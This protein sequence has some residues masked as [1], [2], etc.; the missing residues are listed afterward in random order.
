MS[1]R[2]YL[3][4]AI[5][6]A[7]TSAR[8]ANDR[9]NEY[10]ADARRGLA[11]WHDHFIGTHGG[12]VVLDVR[13]EEEEA[14]LDGSAAQVLRRVTL[15]RAA[16]GIAAAALWVVVSTAGEMSVTDLFQ[17]R[18]YAEELYTGIAIGGGRSAGKTM[19]GSPEKGTQ[20]ATPITIA[21]AASNW[22]ITEL[23]GSF[24]ER[25][26]VDSAMIT[27]APCRVHEH[28][29]GLRRLISVHSASH[30]PNHPV[31]AYNEVEAQSS[32]SHLAPLT[33]GCV[34]VY[35]A[36]GY[37]APRQS[38]ARPAFQSAP[39]APARKAPVKSA[40]ATARPVASPARALGQSLARAFGGAAEVPAAKDQD[41]TEF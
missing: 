40:S 33:P 3:V 25:R 22:R 2:C 20:A 41:W 19:A 10:V 12:A 31:G 4:Y 27:A 39:A 24:R 30:H 8:E 16:S 13:S 17:V 32:S 34:A 5:A 18:T 29:V 7:E 15:R 35:G 1:P 26:G 38:S 21:M 36:G 37:S 9:L 14:L 28:K 23:P 11:V 6:P